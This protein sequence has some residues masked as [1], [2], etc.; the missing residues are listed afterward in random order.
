VRSC[1]ASRHAISA[2]IGTAVIC[3]KLAA[4]RAAAPAT[5]GNSENTPVQAPSSPNHNMLK[6]AIVVQQIMTEVSE[7][8]SEEDKIIDITE[9][10]LNEK[11]NTRIHRSLRLI[12]FNANGIWRQSY[13]LSKQLQV[14]QIDVAVLSQTHL[15]P[16]ERFFV[17]NYH[18]CRTYSFLGSQL[19]TLQ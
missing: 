17:S 10:V 11:M 19:L 5:I 12:A 4:S 16:N 9:M 18:F 2:T 14:L 13:E 7:T 6:F 15:K 1:T 8:A 3:V